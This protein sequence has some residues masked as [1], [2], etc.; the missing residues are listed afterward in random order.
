M[1][2]L[3][4]MVALAFVVSATQAQEAP[5]AKTPEEK[6]AQKVNRLSQKYELSEAQQARLQPEIVK[7][8]LTIAQK[9]AAAKQAR[10]EM[11]Q[12]QSAQE[13][14][15]L[16]VLND[17]QKARYQADKLVR[18]QKMEAKRSKRERLGQQKSE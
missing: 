5:T 8:E 3:M 7:T 13:A 16:E 4:L 18:K 6:A 2:K 11:N 1:K 12:A 10:Q 15:I 9:Q 14:V 17:E